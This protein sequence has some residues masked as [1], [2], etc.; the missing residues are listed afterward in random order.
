MNFL[1]NLFSSSMG[2]CTITTYF[3]LPGRQFVF[4]IRNCQWCDYAS[5]N[6]PLYL[7]VFLRLT[8]QVT[9]SKKS[10]R[11]WQ[12]RFFE[13]PIQDDVDLQRHLNYTHYNPVNQGCVR[14]DVGVRSPPKT[15]MGWSAKSGH[16]WNTLCR[17]VA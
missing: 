9:G 2:Y 4:E 13:H 10:F 7:F 3:A 15:Y 17:S 12:V 16:F 1:Q 6:L 11:H 8:L 14:I 5:H